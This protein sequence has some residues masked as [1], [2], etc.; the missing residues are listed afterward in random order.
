LQDKL[1]A[2]PRLV[3]NVSLKEIDKDWG[4]SSVVECKLSMCKALD[5]ISSR[6]K[7]G[8][9]EGREGGREG[10][11]EGGREGQREC[12]SQ[13]KVPILKSKAQILMKLT[14]PLK[15]WFSNS[16]PTYSINRN[17]FELNLNRIVAFLK[18]KN[19]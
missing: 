1:R 18:R 7:E 13:T 11:R 17:I 5:S 15:Q 4:W 8:R 9:K 14:C 6:R 12:L 16:A 3:R 19:Q 10:E 2:K